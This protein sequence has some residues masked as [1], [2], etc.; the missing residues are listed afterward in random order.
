MPVFRYEGHYLGLLYA[1]HA[2]PEEPKQRNF[3]TIDV[4]LASS[5]DGV[6]W[7]RA[8]GRRPFI[9]NGPPGSIDS[10]EIYTA[11]GPV[12]VGDELWFYYSPG[13][14]EH[15]VTGRSGPICLAKL[16]MDGFVSVDAGDETG[17]MVTKPFRCDG[18][19][20]TINAS[21]RGG[22]VGVAV[23]DEDG[24]QYQGFSRQ[25]CALFDGDSIGHRVTWREK[26]SPEELKGKNIRLKFYLRSSKLYAFTV[27]QG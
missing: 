18:G 7:D 15:G 6:H 1:Y 10:G 22:L 8:G 5:R 23:L 20:L 17:A 4:Q 16:R 2:R 21:A 26:P 3:G 14:M 12:A 25:E 9:P 24:V 11:R 27:G 13:T 19:P